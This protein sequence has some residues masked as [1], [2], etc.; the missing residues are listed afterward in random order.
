MVTAFWKMSWQI[1]HRKLS[2]SSSVGRLLLWCFPRVVVMMSSSTGTPPLLDCFHRLDYVQKRKLWS[3]ER[4]I[5]WSKRNGS[6]L[7]STNRANFLCQKTASN[8]IV[9]Q[10]VQVL[11]ILTYSY[12]HM[13]CVSVWSSSRFCTCDTTNYGHIEISFH[14]HFQLISF[15]R[16][17]HPSLK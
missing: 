1:S 16:H 14:F 8:D 3:N 12:G 5:A 7:V 4:L 11:H 6:A 17:Q 2:S 10:R 13:Q 9:K 15:H